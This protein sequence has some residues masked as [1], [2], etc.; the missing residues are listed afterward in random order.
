METALGALSDP[1]PVLPLPHLLAYFC[2]P[3]RGP[4][5]STSYLALVWEA[6]SVLRSLTLHIPSIPYVHLWSLYCVPGTRVALRDRTMR[7]V[8]IDRAHISVSILVL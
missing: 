1:A 4:P 5:R 8:L 6:W 2:F 3:H 7:E